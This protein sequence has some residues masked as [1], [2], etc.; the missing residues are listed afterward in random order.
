MFKNNEHQLEEV[1]IFLVFCFVKWTI[2]QHPITF[3][4]YLLKNS[5]KQSE[6]MIYFRG[7]K[8][9]RVGWLVQCHMQL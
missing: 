4:I 9:R 7:G 8:V 6:K 5:Q 3:L 1:F 2:V